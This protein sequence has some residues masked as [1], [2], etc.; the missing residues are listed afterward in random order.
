VRE[1]GLPLV[2]SVDAHSVRGLDVLGYGVT[3]A[4]RGGVRKGEV[5]N[6]R[7]AQDFAAAVRPVRAG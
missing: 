7:D 4:R 1:R 2:V 6:A 3:M 5:L